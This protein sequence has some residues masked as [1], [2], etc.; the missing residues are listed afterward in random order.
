[1]TTGIGFADR[2]LRDDAPDLV[3]FTVIVRGARRFALLVAIPGLAFIVA[4]GFIEPRS[5]RGIFAGYAT[6]LRRT[7]LRCATSRGTECDT[8]SS[9]VSHRFRP[10]DLGGSPVRAVEAFMLS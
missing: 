3:A 1:M 10:P 6:Y 7:S 2:V 9:A 5:V 4:F 8:A